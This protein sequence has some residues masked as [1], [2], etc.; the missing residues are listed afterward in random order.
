MYKCV[1]YWSLNCGLDRNIYCSFL[2]SFSGTMCTKNK[3]MG[4]DENIM[5]LDRK[6]AL[7]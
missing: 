1:R 7:H 6:K 3:Q 4:G 2:L 5:H